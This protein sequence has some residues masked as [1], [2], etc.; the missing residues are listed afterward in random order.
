MASLEK[1]YVGSQPRGC[2]PCGKGKHGFQKASVN[3]ECG[4]AQASRTLNTTASND[5]RILM[6]W[7]RGLSQI[8][9][10]TISSTEKALKGTGKKRSFFFKDLTCRILSCLYSL[11]VPLI[12]CVICLFRAK[13]AAKKPLIMKKTGLVSLAQA[14]IYSIYGK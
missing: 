14:F 5:Y 13:R 7:D 1:E 2:N 12:N 6:K 8:S 9:G 11:W 3:S 10:T 4:G